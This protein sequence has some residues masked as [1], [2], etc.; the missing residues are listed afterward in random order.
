MLITYLNTF[1]ELF[2][3]EEFDIF[4]VPTYYTVHLN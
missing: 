2:C 3:N 1:Q 4:W